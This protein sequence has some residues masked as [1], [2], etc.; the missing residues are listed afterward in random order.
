MRSLARLH[1][2]PRGCS[3]RQ[4]AAKRRRPAL[5]GAHACPGQAGFECSTLT[6]PL[7]YSGRIGG[8]L[9]LAVAARRGGSAPRGVLL[10]LT[11][12]PGQPGV[13]FIARLIESTRR[14]GRAVPDRD[15]RPARHGDRALQCPALQ[16]E[17]GFSDLQPPTA[18]AVR[19]CA[20]AIGPKR[21]FFGTDDVVRDLDRLRQ[22]LGRL[23]DGD[24]RHLVR[25]LRRRALRPRLSGPCLPA[26]ARLRRPARGERAARDPGVSAGGAG[27]AERVRRLCR[28]PSPPSS[29][30]TTTARSCWTRSSPSAFSTRPTGACRRR[31]TLPDWET[32]AAWIGCSAACSGA[33]ASEPASA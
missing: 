1:R 9:R 24:R 17:M 3:C 4:R 12:G 18:A 10:V 33:E 27:A 14:R 25:H 16:R 28:R 19:A 30:A 22:A 5:T 11:G 15:D 29:P 6:V 8:T 7:D 20:A 13:P 31:F 2:D 32:A 23:P 21:A 26:R